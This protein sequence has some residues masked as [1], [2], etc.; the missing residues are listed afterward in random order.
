MR[1]S[2]KLKL[3][4]YFLVVFTLYTIGVIYFE[5]QENK[6]QKTEALQARL[7]GYTELVHHYIVQNP[8]EADSLAF[9]TPIVKA[10]PSDVRV[11]VIDNDGKVL[12]DNDI[13]NYA[14]LENH[15]D[16]VEIKGA[17]YQDFG[18]NIRESSSVHKEYLYYAKYYEDYFVRVALPYDIQ[19]Q[20]FLKADNYFIYTIIV[21]FLVVLVLLIFA[22]NRFN[23]SI[24]D[25]REL[26]RKV[27]NHEELPKDI[28]FPNDDLGDIGKELAH[29]LDQKEKAKAAL[30]VEKDKLQMHFK[31]SEEG[32]AIFDRFF[33]REYVNTHFMQYANVLADIPIVNA[34]AIFS[35]TNFQE[36]TDF[37]KN[38]GYGKNNF[39]TQIYKNGKVYEL[40]TIIYEDQSFEL[41][42]KDITEVEKNRRLKQEMTSNIAHELRTPVTALRGF[43]ETMV[44][45]DLPAEKQKQ[46]VDKAYAQSI[47][48]SDLIEDIGLLTKVEEQ[49][50]TFE[51][52]KLDMSMIINN[53]LINEKDKI[54]ANHS[55]FH[56][57]VKENTFV[58]GNYNLLLSVLQNLVENSLKYGGEKTN[59]FIDCYTQ[60]ST[61][62]YF[63]YYDTGRGVDEKHLN[64]IF[65]RFYRV[66]EGRDRAQGGS[67]LGLSIVRNIILLHKGSIQVKRHQS[68]GLQFFFKLPKID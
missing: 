41:T 11:T 29:I 16:R 40:Q 31:Y 48:L 68:G 12:Y 63:T 6:K 10:M 62:Y 53:V 1:L 21:L 52:E 44:E 61:F 26:T 57:E 50:N 33:Q 43:L 7:D 54:L 3:V 58:R 59:F 34:D 65:E 45:Q 20:K 38:K 18:T 49:K 22:A 14:T 8:H 36:I 5:Q 51:F 32:L 64:R 37:V 23:K 25:L 35:D 9:I 15:L 2:F 66:D 47:R 17:L 24:L 4:G 46:F 27:K 13:T 56:S 42:I 19:L 30:E 28:E 60:D 67:G 55:Q 39:E